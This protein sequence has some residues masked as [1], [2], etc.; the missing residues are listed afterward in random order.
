MP[1]AIREGGRLV[2]VGG[3]AAGMSAASRARRLRPD[4]E[5]VVFE[6]GGDVSYAACL[7]PYFISGVVGD[8]DSLIHYDAEFFRSKRAIDVRLHTV[9]TSIDTTR[10]SVTFRDAAGKEGTV[11]FDALVLGTGASAFKPPLPG[12]DM[13]GVAT[14]RGVSDGE[15]IKARIDSGRVRK[16][17][18]IGAGFIGLE[19]AEAFTARGIDVTVIEL[20]PTILST[21]DTDMSEVVER[22]L[23]D[24]GVVLR[25]G[26]GVDG[27]EPR[28]GT[29]DL[30]YVLAGG[31]RLESDLALV[32]I[33]VRPSVRLASDAG[34]ALGAT[35]AIKVDARQVTSEPSVLAA[36]DCAEATHVVTGRPVWIPLGTT[37]NKQGKL[38]GENAVGGSARFGGVAGTSI[39]KVFDLGVAQT[40]LSAGAASEE[41][42]ATESV[43]ITSSSR[44][45]VYPG[46]APVDVKLVF[47][48][49]GGK[50]LG[51]QVIGTGDAAK[52][53]DTVAAAL[54]ARMTV[55]ELAE[56]DMSYAPP[57]SP[58]WDPV[59]MAALQ[60]VKKVRA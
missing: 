60:A 14:L 59:A 3:V 1:P 23:R 33:G 49:V 11:S 46:A 10:K 28:D 39:T 37:A 31:Q 40:G 27:F 25:L 12:I 45:S 52:R 35:G 20:L 41:G 56:I 47:E 24:K 32:S 36:G 2:V 9:V 17:T 55:A 58:V 5:I 26:T 18:V 21:L 42:F 34:I 4:I 50:L 6:S 8:R 16:A 22:E 13:P 15:E 57:F 38:A 51:G 30:G 29:H 43:K 48:K 19:M 7:L 54:H 44:A 53:I